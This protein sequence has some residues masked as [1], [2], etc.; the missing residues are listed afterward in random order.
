MAPLLCL[1]SLL[2]IRELTRDRKEEYRT[3]NETKGN[4]RSARGGLNENKECPVGGQEQD[5][6]EEEEVSCPEK[7][8]DRDGLRLHDSEAAGIR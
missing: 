6:E 8:E 2:I 7:A 3:R 5:E 1:T 4:S